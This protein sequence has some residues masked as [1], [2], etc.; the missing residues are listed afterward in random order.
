MSEIVDRRCPV[1]GVEVERS[2]YWLENPEASVFERVVI[3]RW[4]PC[5]H[6]TSSAAEA[7]AGPVR[8]GE[9]PTT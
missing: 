5:G 6:E 3:T 1:C 8:P 7:P 4:L 2:K 9:E